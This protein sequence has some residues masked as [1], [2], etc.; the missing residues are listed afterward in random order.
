VDRELPD[1][2][3]K[4]DAMAVARDWNLR[5][6]LRLPEPME[7]A[8]RSYQREHAT[9]TFR[10]NVFFI[11]ALYILL[12]S[13]IYRLIPAA[14]LHR[15]LL[16][17]GN[18]GV[19]IMAAA[20]LS[21]IKAMDRWFPLYAGFGSFL[22]V[23]LSVA[24]TGVLSDP[25]AGQL[26]QTAI[27]Y[28]VVIIYGLVG[29]RFG[30]ALMAGWLGGVAGVLLALALGGV[31]NWDLWLRTYLGSSLL[32]MCLAYYAD[33]RARA[34]FLQLRQIDQLTYEDVLTGLPNRRM[35]EKS[36]SR[37]WR[38]ALREQRPLAVLLL[39]IDRFG[40]FNQMHGREAGD[41]ALCA[42]ADMASRYARRPG[43]M[44]ARL[45][46]GEFILL[47]PDILPESANGMAEKLLEDIRRMN[48]SASAPF[49]LSIG[50]AVAVPF[51][52]WNS[53]WLLD[54]AGR[55]A[56]DA[57]Q[58]GGNTWR[59]GPFRVVAPFYAAG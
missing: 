28:A 4:I 23:T 51:S 38:R 10:L 56:F 7:G 16:L 32:G 33:H 19:V 3:E 11:L 18:V 53:Q 15:W 27:I 40:N 1:L 34:L 30:H 24:V 55:A 57:R 22:G 36:L 12:S 52:D 25:V 31:I 44:L 46:G 42:I 8:Y 17:Y 20:A 37:E 13:G 29:L 58:A 48:A 14:D 9:S 49:T 35:L 45:G 26:T 47:L 43:D 6:R 59:F 2:D 21:R 54:A 39:D 50:V 5:F 41:D